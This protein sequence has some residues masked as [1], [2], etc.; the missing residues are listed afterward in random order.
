MMGTDD[1]GTCSGYRRNE[2]TVDGIPRGTRMP[3]ANP[4]LPLALIHR[5]VWKKRRS[6][7]FATGKQRPCDSKNNSN[8]RCAEFP[9]SYRVLYCTAHTGYRVR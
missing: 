7:K 9:T 1:R 6:Q 4:V 2:E 5:S 3:H 8:R